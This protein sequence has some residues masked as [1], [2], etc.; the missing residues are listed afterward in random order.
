MKNIYTNNIYFKIGFL[1]FLFIGFFT[2]KILAQSP[3]TGNYS[4]CQNGTVVG[5]LTSTKGFV[6]T[7]VPNFSG[8]TTGAPTITRGDCSATSSLFK[9]TTHS[10]TAPASGLYTFDMCASGTIWDSYLYLY[11]ASSVN[12]STACSN[13][14]AEND[15]DCSFA[16]F[17]KISNVSLVAGN[18]YTLLVTGYQPSHFGAYTIVSTTPE[19]VEWYTSPSGGSPIASTTP[20]NPVGVP[21]S[22]IINTSTSGTTIFYAQFLGGSTRTAADFTINSLPL[23]S[24]ATKLSYNGSDMT[25]FGANDGQIT[26]TASGNGPF[27]YSKD[28]GL[29]YQGS[30]IFTGLQEDP[31]SIKVADNNGC[32]SSG[33]TLVNIFQPLPLSGTVS[34]NGPICVG[35]LL[36]LGGSISGGTGS[37]TYS[38]AGPN[39][40]SSAVTGTP[41][42]T[43]SATATTAMSGLYTAT[44][45][46]E[47]GCIFNPSTNAIVNP[48]PTATI[49]G[50]TSVCK[51][52]PSPNIT[53]TGANGTAPYTF[54]Y[55]INGLGS[56]TATTIIGNSIDVPVPTTAVTTLTYALVSVQDA[57]VSACTGPASGSVAVIV[58]PKPILISNASPVTNTICE[59]NS[60]IL[61]A[62]NG[63]N[64]LG[65]VT[66]SSI[67]NNN[68]N[69]SIG[70]NWT[71]PGIVPANE[72]VLKSY[73]G[74]SVLGNLSNQQAIFNL[75]GIP[76]HTSVQIDFDLYLNDS[77]DGNS[78]DIIGGSL[79][80]KDIWKMDVDGN[81]LINTTFSNFSYRTQSYPGNIP[82]INLSGTD[83]VSTNL[84]TVCNHG[85]GAGTSVYHI[86]KTITHSN[87]S[88][89]VVLEGLGLESVCNESWSIDN[90]VVQYASQ[91]VSSNI[92]WTSPS[93]TANSIT[94]SPIVN[95]TYTATLNGCSADINITVNP[96]PRADFTINTA[97]QCLTANSYDYTNASTL[98]GPGGM[99]YAWTMTGA[100]TTS[101][102]LQD[103]VGNVYPNHGSYNVTL[104][105]TS[106][107]GN[108]SDTRGI[109][110]KSIQVDP[111]V[112]ITYS[113]STTICAGQS[114]QLTA[115]QVLSTSSS[116]VYSSAYSNN[117]ETAIGS[118]WTFSTIIPANVPSIQVNNGANVLGHL[119]NQTATYVQ[120]GLPTHTSVKIEFD[121]YLNDSWDGN[122][123][124][125]IGGSLIGKDIWKMDVDGN[126]LINTTFSNFS[127]RTQSYPG[128]IP[129]INLSGTDAVSTNLGTICNHGAGAGTSVYH[130][131]KTI[132]H[133][134][135]SISVVL[136]GLGL[137]SVCNESWS[138]DNFN[139]Q[140]GS[141]QNVP[142]LLSAC[143]GLTGA[144]TGPVVYT[145]NASN[146]FNTAIGSEW[147]FSTV[148]P[149][150]VPELKTFNSESVMGY[151]TNQQALYTQ[152]SLATHDFVKVEFDL[153]LHDTWDGNS[154]TSGPDVWK[155]DVN[156]TNIINTTFSNLTWNSA[157]QAYP[158]NIPSTNPS[159]TGEV[160]HALPAVCNLGGG[161]PSSKY[162]IS[163]MVPHTSS[164]L[165]VLLEA[166]GLENICNESWS[167]DNFEVSLG[168]ASG[169]GPSSVALWNG[170][171]VTGNTN[172]FVNVSPATTTDYSVTIGACSSP[173]TTITAN[174]TPAPAFTVNNGTCSKTVNFTNT[175]IQIGVTYSWD[176]GDGS[177]AF[178]GNTP[179][180]HVYTNGSYTITLS[181]S[182]SGACL[183]STTQ[184][185][186]IAD[187]PVSTGITSTVIGCGNTRQFLSNATIA[188]GNTPVYAWNFGESPSP[189]L[190]S[191]V[192][193][194]NT[195]LNSNTYPVT[196]SITTGTNCILNL[197]TSVVVNIVISPNQAIFTATVGGACNNKV[198]TVNTSTGS[199]NQYLW[200]FGDGNTSTAT[201]P[202]HYY[203]DGGVK[204]ITLSIANATGCSSTASQNVTISNNSGS[205]GRVGLTLTVS[206]SESQILLTNSFNFDITILD[207][208]L[209]NP[210]LYAAGLP[211]WTYGDA[212]GSNA[213][214]VFNKSY[215]LV[216]KYTI[217]YVQQTTNTGCFT[218][219]SKIITVLANPPFIQ[220]QN[221]G[222]LKTIQQG[223]NNSVSTTN[224]NTI[225]NEVA[226]ELY[227]NPNEGN[228]NISVKNL[229]I[230]T[231]NYVIVDLLGRTVYENT[232]DV[233]TNNNIEINNLNIPSGTYFIVL[234]N[235]GIIQ[236]RKQFVL[237]NK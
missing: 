117:F 65:P 25:C 145:P 129:A 14:V 216:G 229:G 98:A 190:S 103:I 124:D 215:A 156:G 3:T 28:N 120:T 106:V 208:G 85:A 101:S 178:V 173:T 95:T 80:G 57:S 114:V 102:T 172:C 100:T 212:T 203:V 138:I 61:T 139:L 26:V 227:P 142:N 135:P 99:T 89:S 97:N 35:A 206:P 218:E 141:V 113:P 71:F 91:S 230:K 48:I 72:P 21:G 88:I 1:A 92:V 217:R 175:N 188:P 32:I 10:F 118:G 224:V 94:V 214:D 234:S 150:N 147:T 180:A 67:Y 126:S 199:G 83:A 8:N 82:A 151:L 162:R 221:N 104:V 177:L 23:V 125:I 123:T 228:F 59:G 90:F 171:A 41:I 27:V 84:A 76:T 237:I 165:T 211:T 195:Y 152:T 174:P 24:T 193:P 37:K 198:T 160:T 176:F 179:P 96:T 148:V 202:E 158:N 15:D 74:G 110:T 235:N 4:L 60:V 39:V 204:T 70:S 146:N 169:G 22:G 233:S 136:E 87:P 207:N 53:F 168:A 38:W 86:S 223:L 63:D 155:M 78:T 189:T 220:L 9:Y 40:Y 111:P 13:I 127:Y 108:C 49:L 182:Y 51:D 43:V 116:L 183:V 2:N 69:S 133:S 137:E 56:F 50:P 140:V 149:S 115:N 201:N 225:K 184:S 20:F 45:T 19:G 164:T 170:G 186:T 226:L 197:S 187:M 232:Y 205:N 66:L 11:N 122:S 213:T 222:E 81:S 52:A 18:T 93:V 17:S 46:D 7:P 47:N 154:T 77:W 107:I 130:I 210:G 58:K 161:S 75:T 64:T 157:N 128:N 54:T 236:A 185:I 33:S 79:I 109:K 196:L 42:R 31:Y 5:G 119:S 62:T 153:Y 105:A 192:N 121:L 143:T 134:N 194:T 34:N 12:Q 16:G 166:M 209:N 55:T 132:T 167:I 36:F 73:N 30:N 44:V 131:S 219:I 29:N 191:L 112:V 159:Y 200:D 163:K 181:A 68:F 231:G 144:P 6:G